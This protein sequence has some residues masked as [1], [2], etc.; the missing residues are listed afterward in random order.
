MTDPIATL[1]W[2]IEM[3]ADEAIAESPQNRLD[4]RASERGAGPP[5]AVPPE[6]A[7]ERRPEGRRTIAAPPAP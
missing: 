7:E 4:P 2:L 3:G 5:L 6:P 1:R